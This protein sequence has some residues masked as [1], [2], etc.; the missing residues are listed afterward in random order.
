MTVTFTWHTVTTH[1]MPTVWP[2]VNTLV[3]NATIKHIKMN[4]KRVK[5]KYQFNLEIKIETKFIFIFYFFRIK[6]SN[7]I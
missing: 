2:D 6:R 4:S 1:T 3:E 5:N 7:H